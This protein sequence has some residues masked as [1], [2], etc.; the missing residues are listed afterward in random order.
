MFG[1]FPHP[2]S[3]YIGSQPRSVL[4][5]RLNALSATI[6]N[7]PDWQVKRL[8]PTIVAK[9]RQEAIAQ[10]VTPAQFKFVID[11]LA[12][13]AKLRDGTT[14]VAGVDGV[15]RSFGLFPHE[16]KSDF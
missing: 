11:E 9:W 16:L 6:R 4:E 14:E 3:D 5:L 15:Y 8:N 2:H 13:Y 1:P 12:Y 7:K 10:H